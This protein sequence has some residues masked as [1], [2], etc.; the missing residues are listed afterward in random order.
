MQRLLMSLTPHDKRMMFV[1]FQNLCSVA[2]F[3]ALVFSL[4]NWQQQLRKQSLKRA[5]DHNLMGTE[6]K[7]TEFASLIMSDKLDL[8]HA[9]CEW[10]F[11][12]PNNLRARM[13]DDDEYANWVHKSPL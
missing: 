12:N 13:R 5:P 9:L 1:L 11:H 10:Q 6:D 8:F 4:E 2:P 7:P 3:D